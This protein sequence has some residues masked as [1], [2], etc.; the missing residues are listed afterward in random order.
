MDPCDFISYGVR[1]PGP[2]ISLAHTDR[3][4]AGLGR[5]E[6]LAWMIA[7][8][9]IGPDHSGSSC[10]GRAD[11]GQVT[12]CSYTTECIHTASEVI[13]ALYIFV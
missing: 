8:A 4:V 3:Q 10:D 5:M 1:L 11:I 9:D 13:D 6:L 2:V 7:Q 12:L